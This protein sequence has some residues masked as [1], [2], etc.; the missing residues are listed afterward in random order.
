[1]TELFSSYEEREGSFCGAASPCFRLPAPIS[2]TKPWAKIP[3]G[4]AK[5][6]IEPTSQITTA[7]DFGTISAVA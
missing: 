6:R 7:L 2:L 1:M 5:S 3:K 4:Q